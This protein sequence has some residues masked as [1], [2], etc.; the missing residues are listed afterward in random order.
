MSTFLRPST[1]SEE[2]D[3]IVRK[4]WWESKPKASGFLPLK[5]WKDIGKPKELGGLGFRRFKDMN[6]ALIAKLGWKLASSEDCLYIR[7][8]K[9]KYLQNEIFFFFFL[10]TT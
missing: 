2:L 5:A 9:S 1:L 3:A 10:V 8:L 6:Q 4:F 7:M